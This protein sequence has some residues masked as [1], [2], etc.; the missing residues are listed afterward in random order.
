M[1][2]T[3]NAFAIDPNTIIK[4]QKPVNLTIQVDIETL[5]IK[6][7]A[8]VTQ[9]AFLVSPTSDLSEVLA[10]DSFYLPL[11]PQIDA[12]RT[13]SAD[14]IIWWL[15]EAGEQARKKF[16][17]NKGGDS[18]MLIAFVRSFIR[19]LDTSI[20]VA[21]QTG[22]KVEIVAKGPQFD[23]VIIENLIHQLGEKEPWQYNWIV[24]LRT[25][26]AKAGV[27]TND[28]K[29]DDIVPHVAL[30][31]CR[32]QMRLLDESEFRLGLRERD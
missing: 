4:E 12:G 14:T 27:H 19:K 22:G 7:T 21:K 29:H 6:P 32:L 1:T 8:V 2:D 31:D 26:M 24:D 30:E 28:V 25:L 10:Y 18:D 9:L 11:Q 13:I 15:T 17:Q 23:V 3:T 16:V 5:D 20:Q